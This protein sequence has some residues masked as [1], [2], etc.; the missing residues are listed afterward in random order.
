MVRTDC[1]IISVTQVLSQFCQFPISTS[2]RRQ[3]DEKSETIN[4]T[5]LSEQMAFPKQ[6]GY[7]YTINITNPVNDNFLPG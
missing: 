3:E 2:R 4:Q 1:S 6:Y 7:K 5:H